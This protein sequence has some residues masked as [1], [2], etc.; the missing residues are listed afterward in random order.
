[1][2]LPPTIH[3]HTLTMFVYFWLVKIALGKMMEQKAGD[4]DRMWGRILPRIGASS[5]STCG[6]R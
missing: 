3:T 1:M 5:A 2:L 6:F 4:F